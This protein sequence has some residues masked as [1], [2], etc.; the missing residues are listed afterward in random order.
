MGR[1][2]PSCILEVLLLLQRALALDSAFVYHTASHPSR[3]LFLLF[4]RGPA[5]RRD[6]ETRWISTNAIWFWQAC[7]RAVPTMGSRPICP[8]SGLAQPT[9]LG[10]DC[11]RS[12]MN[13]HH[14][15]M[16]NGKPSR[17]ACHGYHLYLRSTTYSTVML[18]SIDASQAT[19][20]AFLH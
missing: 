17:T 20:Q 11:D 3:P 18:A 14:R 2:T 4:T 16:V 7:P 1:C 13:D 10:T 5:L 19:S 8:P 6:R 9:L 12:R 15:G